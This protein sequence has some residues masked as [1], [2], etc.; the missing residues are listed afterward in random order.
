M[1]SSSSDEE[2]ESY[3]FTAQSAVGDPYC[4]FQ[5]SYLFNLQKLLNEAQEMGVDGTLRWHPKISNAIEINW[6]ALNTS[7]DHVH[8][9]LVRYKLS[10]LSNRK[11]CVRPTMNRKLREWNFTMVPS[12][13]HWVTYIYE[14]N[15]FGESSRH[16]DLPVSRRANTS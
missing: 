10:R 4:R 13:T 5:G 12:G 6:T 7:F 15:L 14:N 3:R 2:E 9:V 16:G 11:G 8:K 1:S